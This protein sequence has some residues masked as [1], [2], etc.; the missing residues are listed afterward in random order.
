MVT[1]RPA[2]ADLGFAGGCRS[3]AIATGLLPPWALKLPVSGKAL[4]IFI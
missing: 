1:Q 4:D 3:Y 2:P